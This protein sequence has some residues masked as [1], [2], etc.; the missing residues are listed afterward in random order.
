MSGVRQETGAE[1]QGY[2]RQVI[3]RLNARGINILNMPPEVNKILQEWAAKTAADI[4]RLAQQYTD[5]RQK[6]QFVFNT[7]EKTI[8]QGF[9][10]QSVD[11]YN[12]MDT[13]RK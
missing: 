11:R 4:A 3:T 1:V 13:S 8:M 5:P 7:I 9:P 2:T 12:A 6:E 10:Q